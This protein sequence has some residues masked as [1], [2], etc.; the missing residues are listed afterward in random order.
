MDSSVSCATG[1]W[2]A[3]PPALLTRMS[4]RPKRSTVPS[5]IDSTPSR[6]FTS[7]LM[8]W[9]RSPPPISWRACSPF[10]AERPLMTT[11]APSRW[12]ASAIARPMPRV[13]PVMAATLPSSSMFPPVD[14]GTSFEPAVR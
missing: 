9:S 5:M 1:A 13:P 12:N 10:S 6:V 4:M 7:A 2:L 3:A 8:K 11:E 14:I